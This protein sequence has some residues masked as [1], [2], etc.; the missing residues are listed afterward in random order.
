MTRFGFSSTRIVKDPS[1]YM[2]RG[3]GGG[4]GGFSSSSKREKIL[5]KMEQVQ[6]RQKAIAKISPD[7]SSMKLD[8]DAKTALSSVRNHIESVDVSY[9][10]LEALHGDPPVFVVNNA[11]SEETCKSFIR[12]ATEV[13][14]KVSS[15]TF[16][17]ASGSTRTST[18]WYL[19]YDK[20]PELIEFAEKITGISRANFE[21]P[22]VVRYEMGQQF[23]WHYDTIPKSMQKASGN[24]RATLLIY[25]NSLSTS[26]GGA[27]CFKDLNVQVKPDL[28]KALLFFPTYQDGENDERTLHCGQVAFDTKYIAQIWIHE[29][30]YESDMR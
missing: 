3:F 7:S 28:G 16:N 14:K 11:F 8:S 29:K 22:Q 18:T 13:G 12:R 30:P 23:S 15:A 20:V 25:L 9:P 2:G 17:S 5:S 6:D 4:G 24:R 19:P 1:L 26:A 27:T 10:G 21:E